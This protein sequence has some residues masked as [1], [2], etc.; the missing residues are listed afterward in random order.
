MNMG[1][2]YVSYRNHVQNCPY[3]CL[4][5]PPGMRDLLEVEC[6]HINGEKK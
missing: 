6:F 2:H 5:R 3:Y 4:R 1:S